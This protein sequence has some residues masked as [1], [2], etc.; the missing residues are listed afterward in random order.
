M[1]C[2]ELK[3]MYCHPILR[4]FSAGMRQNGWGRNDFLGGSDPLKPPLTSSCSWPSIQRL[5]K[6][7]TTACLKNTTA[8]W[9]VACLASA[10]CNRNTLGR[11]AV[12]V[13]KAH[14]ERPPPSQRASEGA[15]RVTAS[16]F[17]LNVVA[18]T[19]AMPFRPIVVF[20]AEIKLT[21]SS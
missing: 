11:S 3:P 6:R 9:G 4:V 16:T 18:R 21:R 1:R 20:F 12:C 7:L 2:C 5:P 10:Q 14:F 19:R 17:A 13:L 8:R 15:A